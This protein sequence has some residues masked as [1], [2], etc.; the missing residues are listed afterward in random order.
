[1][2]KKVATTVRRKIERGGT[3]KLWTYADFEPLPGMAVAA[4]LSRMVKEGNLDRVR[5]GV[6]YKAR[7]T[8]FGLTKADPSRVAAA[9]L[10]RRG[11]AWKASGL[12]A[13]NALGLT[14]QVS[15]LTTFD[16]DRDVTSLRTI[17]NRRIRFR[18]VPKVKNITSNERTV[19]D[20]LRDLRSIPDSSPDSVV[21]RIVELFRSGELSFGR[22]IKLAEAEPPRV[23]AL[24]GTIGSI[25]GESADT[26]RSLKESLNATTTFKLGLAKSIPASRSWGIR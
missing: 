3:D 21:R 14:N 11:I 20:A 10:N 1:M 5:K 25:L 23:K 17:S 19:L 15:P 6:Y 9:V 22:M 2:S 7:K 24:L 26:L 12:A 18:V 4:A 16:V 8:R 13:Y